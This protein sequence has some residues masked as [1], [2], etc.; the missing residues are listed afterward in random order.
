MLDAAADL[1][2]HLPT[3]LNDGYAHLIGY[4][5]DQELKMSRCRSVTAKL[6]G[7]TRTKKGSCELIQSSFYARG[8][9]C[10]FE[11]L[12]E[13]PQL[14]DVFKTWS[15]AF[16]GSELNFCTVMV[17]YSLVSLLTDRCPC[18]NYNLSLNWLYSTERNRW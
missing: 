14:H 1:Q 17:K 3:A 4:D 5:S 10:H 15:S 11:T 12:G 16:N 7:S 6:E 18:T 8:G 2:S 9:I 13:Y